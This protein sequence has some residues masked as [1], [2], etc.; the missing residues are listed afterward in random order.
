MLNRV[1]QDN[2]LA[3]IVELSSVTIQCLLQKS[4]TH[5]KWQMTYVFIEYIFSFQYFVIF[6]INTF[7]TAIFLHTR[8]LVQSDNWNQPMC[9]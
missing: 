4:P 9:Q 3:L 5:I 8:E 2:D 1:T 7:L 6:E